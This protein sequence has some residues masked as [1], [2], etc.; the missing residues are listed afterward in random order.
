MDLI[1]T[2]NTGAPAALS[3]NLS[4]IEGVHWTNDTPTGEWR[5]GVSVAEMTGAKF[6]IWDDDE[7]SL[8]LAVNSS[9]FALAVEQDLVQPNNTDPVKLIEQLG[10]ADNKC[11]VSDRLAEQL[12]LRVGQKTRLEISAHG[13]STE[14]T[15]IGIVHNDMIG[16]PKGGYFAI[17]D[18]EKY[19]DFGFDEDVHIFYV[20]L[21]NHHWNG[22]VV[23]QDIIAQQILDLYGEEYNLSITQTKEI[24]EY[25]RVNVTETTKF[26]ATLASTSTLIAL[27]CLATTM[28]RVVQER[29]RELGLLRSVGFYKSELFR[30]LL[31]ESI[32]LAVL[33]LG[34][35]IINGYILAASY[36]PLFKSIGFTP[37]DAEF[38][39]PWFQ[40]III[41]IL[42]LVIAV[43]GTAF[44]AYKTL[45]MN[46]AEAVHYRG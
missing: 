6:E 13:N 27:L 40:T 45:R 31:G 20:K 12:H 42:G 22:T 2:T 15:V 25:W 39:F 5:P 16:Y 3:G 35:G 36:I 38:I 7:T 11:I 33:G 41:V 26:M 30:L 14:F 21:R 37:Y 19:Y 24:V 43:V 34:I 1:V 46:P 32:L 17:I 28:I 23:D 8:L 9:T 10:D 18:L 29:R 44:P 4:R